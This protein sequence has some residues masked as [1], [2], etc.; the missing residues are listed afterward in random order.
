MDALGNEGVAKYINDH[1][2]ATYLKVGTFEIVGGTKV[3]GNV[4]SYFCT[5]DGSV[6]HAV[7][8][9]VGAK[10][11]LSEARWADELRKTAVTRATD[12]ASG[13]IDGGKFR[14]VVQRAHFER[15]KDEA[16]SEGGGFGLGGGFRPLA[17]KLSATM[18]TTGSKTFKVHWLLTTKSM[19][20]WEEAY[21]IVWRGILREQMSALPVAAR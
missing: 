21:P 1:F 2:T 13:K 6:L 12:L 5:P 4:A 15:Y 18:P 8:G 17:A 11:L 7:A 16:P 14:L 20:K 3:G 9:K 10:E 19:P